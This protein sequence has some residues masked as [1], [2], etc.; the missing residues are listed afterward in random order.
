MLLSLLD[1]A[2]DTQRC[3]VSDLDPLDV[4]ALR[5]W[6]EP[7]AARQTMLMMFS[8]GPV[9]SDWSELAEL[10]SRTITGFEAKLLSDEAIIARSR[11][12]QRRIDRHLGPI[13]RRSAS[14]TPRPIRPRP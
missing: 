3:T 14:F 4:L 9:S 7:N 13:G 5:G 10:A 12:F 1:L 6:D 11:A 2:T 8:L